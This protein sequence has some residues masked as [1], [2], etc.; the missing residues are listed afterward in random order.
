MRRLALALL[1]SLA[2]CAHSSEDAPRAQFEP[3]AVP[4]NPM[5]HDLGNAVGTGASAAV[6]QAT[7]KGPNAGRPPC[8]G[9]C[10]AG[11]YCDTHSGVERCVKDVLPASAQPGK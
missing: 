4:D 5:D 6:M 1:L 2:G 9:A 3:R 7:G 10:A 8:G 11:E